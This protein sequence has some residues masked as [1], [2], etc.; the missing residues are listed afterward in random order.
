[1]LVWAG[2]EVDEE[3][4]VD[5]GDEEDEVDEVDEVEDEVD[6]VDEVDE[7]DEGD[8]VDEVEDEVEDEG[9]EEDEVDEEVD[10][11]AVKE[12]CA[13]FDDEVAFGIEMFPEGGMRYTSL[14]V[15]FLI[16]PIPMILF[17]SLFISMTRMVCC[18]SNLVFD[19]S[20]G[21]P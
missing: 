18:G 19:I 20:L 10:V 17:S 3:D 11:S 6:E 7:E 16:S 4:E 5:E 2:D 15:W 8:E 9:D 1:V 12:R 14:A 21:V 13:C